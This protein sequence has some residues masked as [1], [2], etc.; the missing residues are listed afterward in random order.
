LRFKFYI[1]VA[2][3]HKPQLALVD[4][5]LAANSSGAV[6]VRLLRDLYGVPSIFVSAFPDNCRQMLKISGALG[7]L[8]KPF[9]DDELL[10]ALSVARRLVDG[11]SPPQGLEDSLEVYTAISAATAI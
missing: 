10:G 3:K 4:L 5:H 6:V 11:V 8:S 7:C 2:A 1:E 9:T